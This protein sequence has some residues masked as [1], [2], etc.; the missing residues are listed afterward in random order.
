MQLLYNRHHS[1]S[2][3]SEA[4]REQLSFNLMSEWQELLIVFSQFLPIS[5]HK[6]RIVSVCLQI[7]PCLME[8]QGRSVTF[9]VH[10]GYK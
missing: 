9:H 5:N 4:K 1:K 6:A 8:S 2:K 3:E 10:V 7:T